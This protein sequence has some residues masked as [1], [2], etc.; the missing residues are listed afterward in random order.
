MGEPERRRA[1]KKPARHF[2]ITTQLTLWFLVMA[3]AP[4]GVGTF[5]TYHS[6]RD[7]ME[8]QITT[9]L[10][11][12]AARQGNTIQA[13]LR[14]EERDLTVLANSEAVIGALPAFTAAWPSRNTNGAVYAATQSRYKPVLERFRQA[15]ELED[16]YLVAPDGRVVFSTNHGPD[17]GVDLKH[18]S[19]ATTALGRTVIDAMMTLGITQSDFNFYGPD[20]KPAT[21]IASPVLVD[22]TFVGVIAL[23]L[24][25][26]EINRVIADVTGLSDTGEMV[27]AA[28]IGKEAVVLTPTRHDPDAA[29]HLRIPLGDSRATAIQAAVQGG[30]GAGFETDYRGHRVLATW[31]YLPALRWGIVVKIDAD[32]AFA[33]VAALARLASIIAAVTAILA[34][35]AAWMA[36]RSFS[37]PIEQLTSAVHDI[38]SGD[39]RRTVLVKSRN[40]L[41]ALA[42]DFNQMTAQL[43]EMIETMDEKVR[44]R[45]AEL[46]AA[47]DQ[48]EEANRTKSAFL[49]N[50]SHEL[51][52]PMNAIIGYSEMLIEECADLGHDEFLPDL[53][54]VRSAGK[55][56]LSLINDVLDLSKIEAGK[57]TLF[58]EEFS[59]PEMVSDV[60]ATIQPLVEKNLNRLEIKA[61]PDL[62]RMRADLTKVRQTLF[63]LLSNAS[64]F[65]ENGV[66]TLAIERTAGGRI[67]MR[68]SDTGIGMTPEQ[69]GKLF[70][71]FTQADES[72]TRKYGGTGLGLVISRRFCRLM[73]GDVTVSSEEG[74]G[75][76]FIVDLPATVTEQAEETLVP[77][78]RVPL[79]D[80]TEGAILVI[81]DDPDAADLLTRA[82][83]KGGYRVLVASSG[84]EGLVLATKHRP[85]AI[86]L[87]VMLPGMDGWS[88][89]GALKS[90]PDTADIPVIMVTLLQDRQMGF[91]LGASDYLTKPVDPENLRR[92]LARHVASGAVDALIV[93]DDPASREMLVRLLEKTGLRPHEAENGEVALTKLA[94][95]RPGIVLLDLMMPVM[96]GFEFLA[97]MRQDDA[98]ANIP[99]VV[100]TAKDLTEEDHRRL[101]GSVETVIQKNSMDQQALLQRICSAIARTQPPS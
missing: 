95:I 70:Q 50:M 6:S 54:K 16:I 56:L 22:G 28:L 12:I 98:M 84:M 64:K 72:T 78:P 71:A 1:M 20:R 5:L 93:E 15:L 9:S 44:R 90:D 58:I 59:I 46:A 77:T 27:V 11:A 67:S 61:A 35:L 32:E 17:F 41:G 60:A 29:F 14:S 75:S 18:S 36:A 68:V 89:L 65:T 42:G 73:G 100:L 63:N 24:D 69:L 52:T 86:T 76:T 3:L 51:R 49:A 4:L 79:P 97:V 94:E 99:V 34:G 53:E 25:A 82:L 10:H 26:R 37:R 47:R 92:V 101:N 80:E 91:S 87:D 57:M 19:Y 39:L 45:T 85:L 83:E 21:F 2:R 13:Y 96:D 8:R 81:D 88:V 62:G 33:P 7:L 48:A 23:Q 31:Q 30:R 38:A 74:V 66:V 40:E 55:H 43:R